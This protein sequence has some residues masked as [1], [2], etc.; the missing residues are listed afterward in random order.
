MVNE[1]IPKGYVV[2]IKRGD[3]EREFVTYSGLLELAH[4]HG[5]KKITTEIVREP[6]KEN[7]YYAVVRASV[8]LENGTFADVGDASPESV[9]S[10]LIPHILRLASTRAKARALRDALGIA[11]PAAEEL[12]N[13]KDTPITQ[14]QINYIMDLVEK[15]YYDIKKNKEILTNFLKERD[16]G[17]IEALT[18]T[19]ASELINK[20]NKDKRRYSFAK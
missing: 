11:T 7:N 1:K 14:D 19:S 13:G 20:L 16:L 2:K 9:D 5:L 12:E 17:S 15:E 4:K 3:V 18:V 6:T 8:E 10:H